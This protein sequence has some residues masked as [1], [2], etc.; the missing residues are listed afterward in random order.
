MN[1]R[2]RPTSTDASFSKP[3]HLFLHVSFN[4]MPKSGMIIVDS[5]LHTFGWLK[6][7]PNLTS[8]LG[9]TFLFRMS[10]WLMGKL[11]K[12]LLQYSSPTRKLTHWPKICFL[13]S[14]Y[15][16]S[17]TYLY[18]LRQ[19][20]KMLCLMSASVVSF[21]RGT[22]NLLGCHHFL[23]YDGGPRA[24]RVAQECD[25]WWVLEGSSFSTEAMLQVTRSLLSESTSIWSLPWI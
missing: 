2:Q 5:G 3:F 19:N 18:R 11:S 23:S 1:P 12:D 20:G 25:G 22:L 13:L 17:M 16:L 8:R 4:H 15:V 10:V 7:I 24:K 6:P 14:V 9:N 21:R